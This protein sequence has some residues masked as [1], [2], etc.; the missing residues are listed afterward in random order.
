MIKGMGRKRVY[1]GIDTAVGRDRV[2]IPVIM[3]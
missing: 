1:V 2:F 3:T